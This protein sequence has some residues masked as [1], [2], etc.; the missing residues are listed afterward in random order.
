MTDIEFEKALRSDKTFNR[1][2]TELYNLNFAPD[3]INVKLSIN[4]PISLE[5]NIGSVKFPFSPEK[6]KLSNLSVYDKI[7]LVDADSGIK[8]NRTSLGRRVYDT[9][10]NTAEDK[11]EDAIEKKRNKINNTID[12]TITYINDFAKKCNYQ[13]KNSEMPYFFSLF[14]SELE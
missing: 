8:I 9:L 5:W 13:I 6:L 10:F 1:L 12:K 7:L 4:V 2:N 3:I 11:I 14:L